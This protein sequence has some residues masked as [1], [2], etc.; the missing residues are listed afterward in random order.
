MNVSRTTLY[1][2]PK[3]LYTYAIGRFA[4]FR[5]SRHL[6][7]WYVRHYSIDVGE[8][9]RTIS[10]YQTLLDLFTRRLSSTARSFAGEGFLSPVDGLITASGTIHEHWQLQAKG[11]PYT[12]TELLQSETMARRFVGG[13]FVVLY[14]SPTNYHRIHMPTD[15]LITGWTYVPGRLYPVNRIGLL[16]DRLYAKNERMITYISSD[17][18]EYAIVKIGALGV[19]TVKTVFAPSQREL[20]VRGQGGVVMERENVHLARGE[21][22]GHFEL[23]STVI[24]MWNREASAN[25]RLLVGVGDHVFVGQPIATV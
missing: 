6:I 23:G 12:G 20:R 11:L 22:L 9:E 16:V 21:E 4:R 18:G 5:V 17:L 15:G 14:L 10:E 24:V 7:P 8:M 25:L 19:G 1:L 2:I 13:K 3:R